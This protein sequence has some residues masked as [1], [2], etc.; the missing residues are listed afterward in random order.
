M[1]KFGKNSALKE[2]SCVNRDSIK[3]Q[4]RCPS[5]MNFIIKQY[6]KQTSFKFLND[7][8]QDRLYIKCKSINTD[9]LNLR[10]GK[11]DKDSHQNSWTIVF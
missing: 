2:N 9:F 10:Y 5:I 1:S 4:E 11:I 3:L 7:F 6:D 8:I